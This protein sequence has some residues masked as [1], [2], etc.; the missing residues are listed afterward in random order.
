ME[1]NNEVLKA[2]EKY[3]DMARITLFCDGSG[4]IENEYYLGEYPFGSLEDL[5]R[6]LQTKD[7]IN[8]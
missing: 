6:L 8:E 7:L 5:E 2:L 1:I 3:G 4:Y